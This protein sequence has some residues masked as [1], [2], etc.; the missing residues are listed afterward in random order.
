MVKIGCQITLVHGQYSI[1]HFGVEVDLVEHL[2]LPPVIEVLEYSL[3]EHGRYHL[4]AG[5][6]ALSAVYQSFSLHVVG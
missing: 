6:Q 2:D 5:F 4:C 3:R 1:L